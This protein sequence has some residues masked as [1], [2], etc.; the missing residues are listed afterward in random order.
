MLQSR[1][2][3]AGRQTLGTRPVNVCA[4]IG[5]GVALEN[6]PPRDRWSLFSADS[7]TYNNETPLVSVCR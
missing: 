4:A 6:C 3:F 2:F 7:C 1:V 5:G